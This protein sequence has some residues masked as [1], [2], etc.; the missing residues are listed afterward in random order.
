MPCAANSNNTDKEYESLLAIDIH[1][2]QLTKS[3]PRQTNAME[4]RRWDVVDSVSHPI[5]GSSRSTNPGISMC[6]T[7]RCESTL[8]YLRYRAGYL[9][10]V[11][12]VCKELLDFMSLFE[13]VFPIYQ[14]EVRL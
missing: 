7:L 5:A 8:I 13:D 2:H 11:V 1:H 3:P 4:N 6:Y 10:H 12:S 9:V 14:E